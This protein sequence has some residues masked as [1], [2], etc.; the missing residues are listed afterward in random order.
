MKKSLF[1]I[2]GLVTALASWS[3]YADIK[4]KNGWNSPT[5]SDAGVYT[6]DEVK[7]YLK[8]RSEELKKMIEKSACRLNVEK[9]CHQPGPQQHFTLNGLDSKE[10]CKVEPYS[11]SRSIHIPC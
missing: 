8:N 4:F 9:G 6:E 5:N 11:G 7:T 1:I 3:A 2:I 10:S